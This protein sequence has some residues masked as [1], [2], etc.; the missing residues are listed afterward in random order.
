MTA[1]QCFLVISSCLLIMPI[2]AIK[3]QWGGFAR[4]DTAFDTRQNVGSNDGATALYPE[5]I[6]YDS[7]CCDIHAHGNFCMTPAVTRLFFKTYDAHAQNCELKSYIEV[8]FTGNDIL[9]TGLVKI[10]HAYLQATWPKTT[11]IVGQYFH[12]IV[13]EE[14][15]TD[16]VGFYGGMPIASYARWPQM[17]L[18]HRWH[19]IMLGIAMYS[20]FLFQSPGPDGYDRSYM[21]HSLTPGLCLTA[22]WQH[23]DTYAGLLFNVKRLQ[24]ATDTSPKTDSTKKYVTSAKITSL[25]GSVWLGFRVGYLRMNNQFILG[26][27]GP[28]FN[29]L[30]GY[31]VSCYNDATGHCTYTNI[32][33]YGIWSDWEYTQYQTLTP[34][35]FMGFTKSLGSRN[36]VYLDPTTHEPTFY[37]FDKNLDRV[38][39]IASRMTTLIHNVYIGLEFDYSKAWFG[40]MNNCGKHPNTYSTDSARTLLVVQYNF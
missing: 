4:L 33:Y 37:G 1:R 30:G 26:Q 36:C 11:L 6:D 38:L 27:N 24:P 23:P 13:V 8:D 39:R 29:N 15:F 32:N 40:P 22:E 31:A 5:P 35:I 20:Q 18:E 10:R 9:T 16:T 3:Y 17:R 14:C 28:D 19:E 21:R 7:N 25:M 34:G 2:N 12:P